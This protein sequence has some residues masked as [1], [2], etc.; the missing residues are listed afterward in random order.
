MA[1]CLDVVEH[2]RTRTVGE[3]VRGQLIQQRVRPHPNDVRFSRHLPQRRARR[4]DDCPEPKAIICHR[5]QRCT[6]RAAP[7]AVPTC[8]SV[9]AGLTRGVEW[10]IEAQVPTARRSR[11]C[12][13][14]SARRSSHSRTARGAV[15]L[16]RACSSRSLARSRHATAFAGWV[17]PSAARRVTRIARMFSRCRSSASISHLV[18][19]VRPGPIS[20]LCK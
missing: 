10:R 8:R 5:G 20:L 2:G 1:S 14:I 9:R 18:S 3:D 4:D 16:A 17:A 11:S 19:R 7:R 15:V 13:S 6:V 12:S